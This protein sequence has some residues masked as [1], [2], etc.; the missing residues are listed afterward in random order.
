MTA[1]E[2]IK[3]HYDEMIADFKQLIEIP[4][5]QSDPQP[6]APF[7]NDVNSAL[8]FVGKVAEK[9][10][11]VFHNAE[12][13]LGYFDYYDQNEVPDYGIITHVD[14]VPPA[15]GKYPSFKLTQADGKFYGRGTI[16]DKGP[17]I[18]ML[19][20]LAALKA[21][22]FKPSEN[23]R[24]MFGTNEESGWADIDYFKQHNQ[25]PKYGFSPDA[26][27]PLIN[28]EKGIMQFELSKLYKS[29]LFVSAKSGD[30]PNMVPAKAECIVNMEKVDVENYLNRLKLDAKSEDIGNDQT[31]VTF[32][33]VSAH[34]SMPELGVNAAGLMASFMSKIDIAFCDIHD[35]FHDLHGSGICIS[36]DDCTLNLGA[37]KYENGK[38]KLVG[39]LR[40]SREY[41]EHDC[42]NLLSKSAKDYKVSYTHV[43]PPHHVDENSFLVK[44][45]LGAYEKETGEKGKAITIGGGTFSRVFEEGVAFGCVFPGEEMV[46]HQA[47]EYFSEESF[48]KNID[49]LL[50]AVC[51][52]IK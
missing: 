28:S 33:G 41:T 29:D 30:R 20:V 21:T 1:K 11:F 6:N 42:Q 15:E 46:A 8:V 37:L 52:L 38:L 27:Y 23:I 31:L 19:Y 44:T 25:M 34:A 22:G 24:M 3:N 40:F 43:M 4:S 32:N 49:I 18:I 47:D 13:Y 12:G 5:V 36:C 51:E 16:D 35:L 26:D 45:L 39:D 7:G 9:F 48:N 14:V 17:T 10:G 50:T 2:W